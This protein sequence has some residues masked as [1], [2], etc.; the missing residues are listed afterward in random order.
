M[1]RTG[2][3]AGD[4]KAAFDV[5]DDLEDPRDGVGEVTVT[6]L[7]VGRLCDL[8]DEVSL[9]IASSR[10]LRDDMDPVKGVSGRPF[11]GKRT[12][13]ISWLE[14][15]ASDGVVGRKERVRLGLKAKDIDV[16][17]IKEKTLEKGKPILTAR[18]RSRTGRPL[19]SPAT[20]VS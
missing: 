15:I 8:V 12:S 4:V 2:V 5:R 19:V 9:T 7:S 20:P 10:S 13:A 6:E 18:A 16:V 11:W 17:S 14:F 1:E 3:Y